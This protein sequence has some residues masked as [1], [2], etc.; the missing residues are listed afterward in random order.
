M[1]NTETDETTAPARR[2]LRYLCFY[3]EGTQLLGPLHLDLRRPIH[4]SDKVLKQ[5]VLYLLKTDSRTSCLH[6]NYNWASQAL[7]FE[8]AINNIDVSR[9]Q[10]PSDIFNYAHILSARQNLSQKTLQPRTNSN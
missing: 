9:I 3:M 5:A 2:A 1:L 6:W 4:F 7:K 10:Y 8:L